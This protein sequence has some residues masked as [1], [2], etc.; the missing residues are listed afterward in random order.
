[1][2]S[3]RKGRSIF[4]WGL[5]PHTPGIYRFFSARMACFS[6]A[7]LRATWAA[8]PGPFRPLN[9]SLGLLPSSCPIPSDSGETSMREAGAQ[10]HKFAANGIV[11]NLQLSHVGVHLTRVCGVEIRLEALPS[12][13]HRDESR[14]SNLRRPRYVQAERPV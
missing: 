12:P 10:D 9:R 5:C 4:S 2:N 1:M 13:K 11:S 8:A 14:C 7:S 6:L 3:E